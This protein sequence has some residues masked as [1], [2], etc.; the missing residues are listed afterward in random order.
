MLIFVI[1]AHPA[2]T[3]SFLISATALI[4][5]VVKSLLAKASS[6]IS[7]F[8]EAPKSIPFERPQFSKALA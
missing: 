2:K 7:K 4:F 8:F 5:N 6:Q 3:L 1:L